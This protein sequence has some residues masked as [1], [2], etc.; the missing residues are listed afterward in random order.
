MQADEVLLIGS[1]KQGP[2]GKRPFQGFPALMQSLN[3]TI[4][5]AVLCNQPPQRNTSPTK[6]P[7]FGQ[8]AGCAQQI[9][10]SH[11]TLALKSS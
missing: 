10:L 7:L 9:V 8:A 11:E 1:G 6:W 5:Q 4:S 2:G 3:T